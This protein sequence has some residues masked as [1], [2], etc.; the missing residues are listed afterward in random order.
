MK[1]LL[2]EYNFS[3]VDEYYAMIEESRMNGNIQQSKD[4]FKAMPKQFRKDLVEAMYMGEYT[5]LSK[6]FS[7]FL[8]LI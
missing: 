7:Q 2:K 8:N 4:Q 6:I 5:Q 3:N 1:K